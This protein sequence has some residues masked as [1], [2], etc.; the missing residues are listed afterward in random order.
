MAAAERPVKDLCDES[1]CS[2][3]LEY[4]KDPVTIPECGHNF[5][6]AGRSTLFNENSPLCYYE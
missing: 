5:C 4:F 2:I 6:R 3:C 1:T